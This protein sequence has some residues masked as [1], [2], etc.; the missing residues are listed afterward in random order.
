MSWSSMSDM[1]KIFLTVSSSSCWSMRFVITVT[2]I[3]SAI[4]T[5]CSLWV[6]QNSQM[7]QLIC[8]SKNSAASQSKQHE[9]HDLSY[10]FSIHVLNE[11]CDSSAVRTQQSTLIHSIFLILLQFYLTTVLLLFHSILSCASCI[12]LSSRT[13]TFFK[14]EAF[15]TNTE[16]SWLLVSSDYSS[17][18][19]QIYI[20][21]CNFIAL[22]KSF[23]L[24]LSY[25]VYSLY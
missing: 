13:A 14:K 25:H 4:F 7:S 20:S 11:A 19:S 17:C 16:L 8:S 9:A 1:R 18:I 22:R 10:S 15:V 24:L 5:N 23:F 2:Q 12:L 3:R 6:R 21:V